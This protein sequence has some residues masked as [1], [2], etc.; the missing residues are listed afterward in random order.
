MASRKLSAESLEFFP[1]P[2]WPVRALL[3]YVAPEIGGSL[4][5]EPACGRGDMV[6]ALREGG[7]EVVGTDVHDYG[8]GFQVADF[9]W[10]G[11]EKALGLAPDWIV[12]NPPFKPAEAF[13]RKGLSIARRGV[14]VFVRLQF[15]EG[16]DRQRDLFGPLPPSTI[17]LFSERVNI[18]YGRLDRTASQATAYCWIVWERGARVSAPTFRWIRPCR[19]LLDR[20]SD[21]EGYAAAPAAPLFAGLGECA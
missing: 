4:V 7:C 8:A 19:A 21:Y 15:L 18:A 20:A 13:I 12:T 1:T 17:A 5:W 10:P 14:A 16:Q 9:L 6:R 11:S 3:R 2:P